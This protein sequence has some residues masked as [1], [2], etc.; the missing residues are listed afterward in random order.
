MGEA[1]TTKMRGKQKKV[2]IYGVYGTTTGFNETVRNTPGGSGKSGEKK[3][4]H[5]TI[6]RLEA[7]GGSK[8]RQNEGR[9][10]GKQ[11]GSKEGWNSPVGMSV[12]TPQGEK[13]IED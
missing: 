11:T 12:G 8:K 9:C 3:N 7:G 10:F 13:T 2:Q 5:V 4:Y 1:Q 6:L